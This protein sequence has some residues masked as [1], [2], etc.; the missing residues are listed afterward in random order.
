[1][2]RAPQYW[3]PPPDLVAIELFH[4]N[5][6]QIEKFRLGVEKSKGLV[7][8][9]VHP[10]FVKGKEGWETQ[11]EEALKARRTMRRIDAFVASES[12]SKP[13]IVVFEE[14]KKLE[15]TIDYLHS[16]A[17]ANETLVTPTIDG[18]SIPALPGSNHVVSSQERERAWIAM[19]KSL[20]YLGAKKVLLGGMYLGSITT[21]T[22]E[23]QVYLTDCVGGVYN[24]LR[25]EFDVEISSF[26]FPLA[27][28]DIYRGRDEPENSTPHDADLD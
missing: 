5:K 10:Y 18:T 8:L 11:G 13:P 3:E 17:P 14:S 24:A 7:L 4:V 2:E 21:W 23:K 27:R 15:E 22:H 9:L 16:I 12:K 1:M 25:G 6:E 26:T 19:R 20:H 28:K